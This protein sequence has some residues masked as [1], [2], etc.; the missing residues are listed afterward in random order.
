MLKSRAEIEPERHAAERLTNL[1][2]STMVAPYL[3]DPTKVIKVTFN[4][5]DGPAGVW[6][7]RLILV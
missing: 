1:F 4:G 2:I 5:V 3:Y 6:E 7:F